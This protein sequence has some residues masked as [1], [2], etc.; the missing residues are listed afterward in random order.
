[1]KNN[2]LHCCMP[3]KKYVK[4]AVFSTPSIFSICETTPV[5][6]KVE[7]HVFRYL[8]DFKSVSLVKKKN[9][10]TSEFVSIKIYPVF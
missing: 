10:G 8:N 5:I 7:K 6:A 9:P 2:V 3:S 4:G 1:M